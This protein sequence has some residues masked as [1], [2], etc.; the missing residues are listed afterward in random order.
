MDREHRERIDHLLTGQ[1][2]WTE[3]E[4]VLDDDDLALLRVELDQPWPRRA[5][6]ASAEAVSAD[7]SQAA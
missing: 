6:A 5:A 2:H 1:G 3:I 4:E 7:W